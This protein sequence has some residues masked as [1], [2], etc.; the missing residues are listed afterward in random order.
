MEGRRIDLPVRVSIV[1]G[2]AALMVGALAAPGVATARR[3]AKERSPHGGSVAVDPPRKAAPPQVEKISPRAGTT[4]GG[5]EVTI[6][7]EHFGSSCS[8]SFTEPTCRNVI[9]YFGSEPGFV[10]AASSSRI[11]AFSPR[12]VAGTVMV[13]VVTPAGSSASQGEDQEAEFTYGG[14]APVQTPGAV[15]VVSA[16][17]PNHG[18]AAG[19]NE[20]R[21]KGE[22]LTPEGSVCIECAGDV[23][24]FGTASVVVAQGTSNELLVVAPPHARGTVD[25]IVTTNPGGTSATG[26]ADHYRFE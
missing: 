7:G 2:L 3:P 18:P 6:T 12:H 16:V 22:H 9:V 5:T 13:T 10:V 25:V 19:F 15:P 20:V 24:H 26:E 8:V 11:L 17:E 21:I 14:A 23:V 1:S 4:S